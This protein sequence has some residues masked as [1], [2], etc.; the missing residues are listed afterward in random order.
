VAY[1]VQLGT[2]EWDAVRYCRALTEDLYTPFVVPDESYIAYA[3]DVA[4][5]FS[6]WVPL[7]IQVGNPVLG[8]SAF[9]TVANQ[10][11]YVCNVANG[12]ASPV[13]RVTD[14]LYRATNA[15]SAASE[16]SYLALLPFSPLNRFLFTPSLLDSPSERILRDEYLSELDHYGKGYWGQVRDS[17]TGTAAIDLYP[18]PVTGGLPI[19]VRYQTI[20]TA[21]ASPL[22]DAVYLRVPEDRKRQFA[23][24][25][26]CMVLEQES[27][28]YAK[29]TSTSA[30]ILRG[31]ASPQ[32]LER[33]IER[34]RSSVYLE[35]GGALPVVAHTF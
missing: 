20:H 26:Y 5:D 33:K 28:R 31:T 11:R 32:A 10:Q 9:L 25:L 30:G 14:V 15:F 35:L 21:T 6:R 7:D 34:I 27:G 24:L 16:I 17:G 1:Q 2:T 8:T 29:A 13:A 19:F 22:N 3:E 18:I 12:F 23:R 4:E